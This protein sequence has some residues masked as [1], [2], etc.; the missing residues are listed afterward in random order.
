M[1]VDW[2]DM[3]AV[4]FSLPKSNLLGIFNHNNTYYRP[5]GVHCC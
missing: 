3:I 5:E 1:R 4:I 2:H